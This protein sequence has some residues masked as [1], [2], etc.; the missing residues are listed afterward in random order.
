MDQFHTKIV[1]KLEA[2][3][4]TKP[5]HRCGKEEF[6]VVDQYSDIK[7]QKELGKFIIGGSSIPSVIT[8][9]K[10]CGAITQHALGALGML[11]EQEEGE[12]N[13]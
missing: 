7:I 4:A 2:L 12:F 3:G 13:G 6:T 5:C 11:P 10:N 1:K 8:I 9:C